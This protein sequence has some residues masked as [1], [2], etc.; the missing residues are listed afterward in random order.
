[1]HKKFF[2]IVVFLIFSGCGQKDDGIQK[3]YSEMTVSELGYEHGKLECEGWHW[4]EEKGK[5]AKSTAT[6]AKKTEQQQFLGDNWAKRSN[7]LMT[8]QFLKPDYSV[9]SRLP[10]EFSSARWAAIKEKCPQDLVAYIEK[11]KTI[12]RPGSVDKNWGSLDYWFEQ[13]NKTH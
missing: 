5:E 4:L 3:D 7:V 2:L 8:L 11:T 13:W 10:A 6:L 9:P 1:M 12:Y